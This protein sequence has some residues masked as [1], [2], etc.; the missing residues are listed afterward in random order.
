MKIRLVGVELFHA[1]RQMDGRINILKLI[2]AFRNFVKAPELPSTQLNIYCSVNSYKNI[3]FSL[4]KETHANCY[5][6][7]QYLF[8]IKLFLLECFV[9]I[10]IFA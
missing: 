8:L 3:R 1:D 6:Y 9:L 7:L 2:A 10:L 4:H 5:A